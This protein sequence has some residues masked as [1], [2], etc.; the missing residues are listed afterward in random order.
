MNKNILRFGCVAFLSFAIVSCDKDEET[1]QTVI[2]SEE[3]TE[4]EF[5]AKVDSSVEVLNDVSLQA[6][7]DVEFFSKSPKGKFLPDCA[8]RTVEQTE[9]SKTVTID[10]GTE[11]CEVRNGHVLKGKLIMSYNR[12]I[13]AMTMTINHEL[14]DFFVDD[15][16]MEGTKEVVRTRSNDNGNP[17]RSM[18]KQ[19]TITFADGTQASRTGSRTR[20]WVEGSFDGEWK[21]NVFEI[22]GAWETNFV[23]GVTH[24]S[25]IVTPL[26]REAKCKAIVSGTVDIVR[27]NKTGTLDYGDGTCD[28]LAVFT[29]ADGE[30]IE[31]RL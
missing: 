3:G 30:E 22:T 15:I 14:V 18:N 19:L 4:T 16:K 25:T 11:G 13:E 10:F 1:D 17:Q 28:R 12:D 8:V 6:F 20:E 7:G 23:D 31:I 24:S 9:L 26:R 21:N 2:G 5:V 27:S 29:N